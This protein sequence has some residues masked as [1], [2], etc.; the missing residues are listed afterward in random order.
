MTDEW[1]WETHRSL[2][3]HFTSFL[4]VDFER[5]STRYPLK[6]GRTSFREDPFSFCDFWFP[7][8]SDCTS[9]YTREVQS[10]TR[11]KTREIGVGVWTVNPLI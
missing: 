1:G 5:G 2:V 8:L 9:P 7:V 10:L 11:G 3:V 4:R 6:I